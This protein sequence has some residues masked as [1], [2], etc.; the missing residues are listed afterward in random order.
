M[1]LSVAPAS[2]TCPS[3]SLPQKMRL[4]VPFVDACVDSDAQLMILGISPSSESWALLCGAE[5][6]LY[7]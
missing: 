3:H 6:F 2:R 4:S 7:T 5:I 1:M